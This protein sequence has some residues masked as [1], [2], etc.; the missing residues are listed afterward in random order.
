M[1][2]V[3]AS[4]RKVNEDKLALGE[5]EAAYILFRQ[6][7][8]CTDCQRLTK[9]REETKLTIDAAERRVNAYVRG[10]FSN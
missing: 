7:F 8:T 10:N 9:M 1:A 6:R 2:Y 4:M 5:G 3:K